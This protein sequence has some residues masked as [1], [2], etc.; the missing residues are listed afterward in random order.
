MLHTSTCQTTSTH[1]R[2]CGRREE[3]MNHIAVLIYPC[4]AL[5]Y[6]RDKKQNTDNL[7]GDL[8]QALRKISSISVIYTIMEKGKCRKGTKSILYQIFG[9]STCRS[10]TDVLSF[11]EPT[12]FQSCADQCLV[13]QL[14]AS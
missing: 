8:K 9:G 14:Q 6:T 2:Y 4:N 3:N 5:G 7:A 1:I 10:R 11:R 13:L 12:C